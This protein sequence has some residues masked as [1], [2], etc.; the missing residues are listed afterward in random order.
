MYPFPPLLPLDF[1]FFLEYSRIGIHCP[2]PSWFFNILPLKMHDIKEGYFWHDLWKNSI[3]IP[4]HHTLTHDSPRQ[5]NDGKAYFQTPIPTMHHKLL[6]RYRAH[7]SGVSPSPH[8]ITPHNRNECLAM[9]AF[10][11][12]APY[13][14]LVPQGA[15][16]TPH[17]MIG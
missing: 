2:F 9:T 1:F 5:I 4:Q 12:S 7:T 10:T 6:L 3:E 17:R 16:K 11:G 8:P 14:F 15:T 13:N